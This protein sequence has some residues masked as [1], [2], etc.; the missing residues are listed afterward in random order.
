VKSSDFT[1]YPILSRTEFQ[2]LG[3]FQKV[4]TPKP[5]II[6]WHENNHQKAQKVLHDFSI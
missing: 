3:R 1:R 6:P 2:Q 5:L 4:I